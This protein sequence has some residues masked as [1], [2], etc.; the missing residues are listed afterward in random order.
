M[1]CDLVNEM[2]F[3]EKV[4]FP[5]L[6]WNFPRSLISSVACLSLISEIPQRQA[7]D[8]KKFIEKKTFW[9][10]TKNVNNQFRR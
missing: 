5:S 2:Y 9:E 7:K 6:Y 4:L 1:S 10:I 3:N 8:M